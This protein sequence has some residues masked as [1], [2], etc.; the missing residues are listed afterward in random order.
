M[1]DQAV[2]RPALLS[3]LGEIGRAD[4]VVGIPSY[5]NAGSIA[6]VLRAVSAGVQK[7]FPDLTSVVLNSDGGSTDGTPERAQDTNTGDMHTVFVQH[8]LYP[9]H[10]IVTSYE[11]VPARGNAFRT[12]LATAQRLGAHA[13][14]IVDADTRSITPEWIESLLHPILHDDVDLVLPRYA[15][16]KYDGLLNTLLLYPLTRALYGVD[17]RQVTGGDI[18]LA[19]SRIPD[20]LAQDVWETDV[21]RYA[22]DVWLVTHAL[23]DGWKPA[24]SFL[25]AKI[26]APSEKATDP[27]DLVVETVGPVFALMEELTAVWLGQRGVRTVPAYGFEYAVSVDPINVNVERII[28]AFRY[29]QNVLPPVWREILSPDTMRALGALSHLK[30]VTF[31]FPDELWVRVIAQFAA[32]Y[33]RRLMSRDHLL[34]SLTPLYMGKVGSYL[35]ES[36]EWDA[37]E[38]E[39]GT[40]TLA[41]AFAAGKTGLER[42]WQR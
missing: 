21:S 3:R 11:G 8:P 40:H 9:V 36:A 34:R 16:H 37:D 14:A 27:A 13:V 33:H 15:R 7:Y 24:Q 23:A 18:A 38:V 19:G 2:L 20:L 32:A 28:N 4:I 39:A 25:G 31:R 1:P 17:V 5:N 42:E 26:H 22:I 10:R 35:L 30:T 6:H 41:E 12:I 29:G